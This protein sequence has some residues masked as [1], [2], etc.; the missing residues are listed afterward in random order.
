M[1][2][3]HGTYAGYMKHRHNGERPCA[4]CKRA[5]NEY[6][7]ARRVR[8]GQTR[9]A[10]VPLA[11]LGTLLCAAPS[12]VEEWAEQQLGPALTQRALSVACQEEN[13][14]QAS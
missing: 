13:D 1:T 7:Q 14:D 3:Q 11:V 12:D 8:T 6:T 5:Q 10:M 9:N 2:G 4:A